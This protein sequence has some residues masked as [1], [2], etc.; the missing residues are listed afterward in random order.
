MIFPKRRERSIDSVSNSRVDR[1]NGSSSQLEIEV[2]VQNFC[3]SL[4]GEQGSQCACW[5]L[6]SPVRS[7]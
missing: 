1:G 5:L 3:V 6:I 4:I 7:P 2:K